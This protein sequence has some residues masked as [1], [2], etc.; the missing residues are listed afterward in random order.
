[1]NYQRMS[2]SVMNYTGISEISL[3]S[4]TFKKHDGFVARS[5]D[6][7]CPTVN[8][9]KSQGNPL[10]QSSFWHLE[11]ETSVYSKKTTFHFK[12]SRGGLVF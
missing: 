4:E 5:W 8:S 3:M 7:F 10:F 1:M 6:P 9:S 12:T 2:S 11:L